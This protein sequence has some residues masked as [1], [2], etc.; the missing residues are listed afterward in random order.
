MIFIM[1][2][3]NK[4]PV[5]CLMGPT[6][7]GKTDL[8]VGLAQRYSLEI[9]SA[10]SALVYRGL[11]IGTAKPAPGLLAA[12]PHRLINICDPADIYSAGHFCKDALREISDIHESG[13]IP[14]IVGGT[15]LYFWV[16]QQGMADLPQA[17]SALRDKIA[18]KA[19]E[20]SWAQLHAELQH[21]DA[22]TAARIHPN[23]SQRIQRA[24]EVYY[25]TGKTMS[26]WQTQDAANAQR[27]FSLQHYILAPQDSER[28]ALHR[29][30]EQRLKSLFAR[31]FIEEVQGLRARGD[32]HADLPSMRT[33][34]Y[35][36][37]WE[38]L[39]GR[40]PL[41]EV[42]ERVYIATCQ[43]A[44]RQMTWLRRWPKATW[45]PMGV[46]DIMLP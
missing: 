26:A 20:V 15:M 45:L 7:S 31:G 18:Q 40:Y 3:L 9:I 35:R 34:G 36:Q 4:P 17:D 12:A 1:L 37:I 42:Q 22:K 5:I 10:D 43:L 32:L 2:K 8:A 30:I 25:L 39:E 38:A 29:R 13:K 24:L 16:L 14:L 28:D 41:S 46:Q 21:V 19:A 23:D 44:K 11:D 27:P 33:V 6:A